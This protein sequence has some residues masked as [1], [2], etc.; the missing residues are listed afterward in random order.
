V[1]KPGELKLCSVALIGSMK[2]HLEVLNALLTVKGEIG[3]QICGPVI[4][5][6]YWKRCQHLIGQMPANVSVTYCGSIA[7]ADLDKVLL[8]N[9]LFILP[10]KSE[11]YGHSI[12]EA[13]SA[14]RPVITSNNTP[15]NKLQESI[16]GMNVDP[17]NSKELVNAIERFVKM[18]QA[19]LEEWGRK[20]HEYAGKSVDIKMIQQ[21]YKRMFNIG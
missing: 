4:D 9:H 1:K 8:E 18:D 3:Y 15:W 11:N 2:N 20:A 16:A 6:T 10:S 17:E 13:L 7:P 5:E 21:Q 14:G 19:E 12:I